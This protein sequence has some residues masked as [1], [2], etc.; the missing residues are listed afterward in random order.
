MGD[1]GMKIAQRPRVFLRKLPSRKQFSTSWFVLAFVAA[2]IVGCAP[3]AEPG[4][5]TEE[6]RA[7]PPAERRIKSLT[8]AE[9]SEPQIV[10]TGMGFRIN[11][12]LRNAVHHH[13]ATFDHRGE[14]L[15]QLAV[16]LPSQAKGT[17]VVRPDGTM[18]T[19]YNLRQDVTWHD[20][21]PLTARD[22]VFGWQVCMD[23]ELPI[24]S[25]VAARQIARIDTPDD[26]TLVI[27]WANLYASAH[28]L[29][30]DDLGPMPVHL[31]KA[32]YEADKDQFWRSPYWT[33][34]FV[35]VGPYRMTEWQPG[36]HIQLEAYDRFY[37]GRAKIDRITL[38]FIT[39][40]ETMVAQLLSGSA[41]F[42]GSSAIGFEELTHVRREWERAGQKPTVIVGT[43]A[44]RHVWV[45]HRDPIVRELTDPR[46]KRGLMY[47]LDRQALSDTLSE[48]FGPVSD[49]IIP[50]DDARWEWVKDHLVRYP[51]DLR[52][53]EQLFTEA[54]LRKGADGVWATAAGQ[55]MVLPQ[56]VNAGPQNE[57]EMAITADQWKTFGVLTEQTPL[58]RSQIGDRRLR[59]GFPALYHT[60]LPNVNVEAFETRFHSNQCPTEANGWT[61][62]NYG[63]YLNPSA[64]QLTEQLTKSIDPEEQR[65]LHQA[66]VR[67]HTEELP[68][69]PLF[70]VAELTVARQG[71]TGIKGRSKPEGDATWNIQEWDVQ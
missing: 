6:G 25:R 65:R 64:D 53:A 54:G 23:P 58:S 38:R 28:A 15:P 21:T 48:G 1:G 9:D 61:G 66:L 36:S 12:P 41:D 27:E 5:G 32:A 42:S 57:R 35:G 69:L 11:K 62:Q 20:G 14:V 70:F 67:L 3:A 8:I 56:W 52:Q 60:S 45:Q 47:A 71:I 19:R 2:L 50:P 43:G 39:S 59:A 68:M 24:E 51:F 44:W 49:T 29:I 37:G 34:E 26:Y 18:Q 16:E 7:Q 33:R 10:V 13:L 46:V 17:W 55:R 40:A 30:N 22:F 4:R 31:L 63:C